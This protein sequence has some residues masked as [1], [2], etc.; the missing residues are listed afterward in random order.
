MALYIRQGSQWKN[1]SVS[2]GSGAGDVTPIGTIALWSGSVSS[3]PESEGWY[4]CNGQTAGGVTT[5]DLR[6]RFVIGADA[7]TT[8]NS[9]IY[10]STSVTGSATTTGGSANATL[11]SHTHT[12]SGT[13]LTD[14]TLNTQ[15]GAVGGNTT[16]LDEAGGDG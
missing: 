16:S 9:V 2:S 14:V 8:I 12:I 10:P 7:D 15:T 13:F 5:P 11:V 4:L 6:N 1:V 3:I